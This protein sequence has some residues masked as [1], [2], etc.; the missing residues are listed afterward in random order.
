MA[1]TPKQEARALSVDERELVEMSRPPA[2]RVLTDKQLATL[3]KRMR[4]GRD[5]ARTVSERQRRELRG[6]AAA[7]GAKSVRDDEGSKLKLSILSAALR[8][9]E[10][11]TARR[12]RVQ[13]KS[14]LVE[15][16]RKALALKQKAGKSG[17]TPKPGA[18]AAR[19]GARGKAR[20]VV[21]NHVPRSTRGRVRKHT[22]R[23][24]AKRDSRPK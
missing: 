6:K 12:D 14:A 24:Q 18:R 13:A 2:L 19:S 23:V 10:T 3:L 15:S 4:V 17:P 7:R 5:K 8:R 22:A 1:M 20:V 11:E 9:L 16:A 21:E